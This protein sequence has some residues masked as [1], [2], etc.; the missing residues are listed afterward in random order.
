MHSFQSLIWA[1]LLLIALM[2]LVAV[3]ILQFVA[4]ECKRHHTHSDG[5]QLAD[6][7]FDKLI[8]YY[9]SLYQTMYTL[10]LSI[11]S[12]VS[13]RE[14]AAPLMKLSWMLGTFFS[15]YIAFAVLCVLNIITGVFVENAKQMTEDDED[16]VLMEQLETRRKWFEEVKVLFEA[17]DVDGSG[18]L[19]AE[20]FSIQLQDIRMQAWFRKIGVQVESYSAAGLFQLLDFD[21]DGS[22]DLDEFAIAL[23]QVHGP[24]R[25]IDVAKIA[26]DTRV[27]RR[28]MCELLE[29]CCYTLEK[30]DPEAMVELFG[31]QLETTRGSVWQ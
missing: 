6:E 11:T 4:D 27:L 23:Q 1:G 13:W 17:A 14:P 28:E 26:H 24:A 9:N 29:V 2:Y 25:S 7:D 12:G 15:V 21:G 3:W 5:G 20:E 18:C 10:Y 19:N 8:F 22:L 31:E 16:M 30:I